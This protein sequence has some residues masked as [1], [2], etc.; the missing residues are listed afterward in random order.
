MWAFIVPRRSH[1]AKASNKVIKIETYFS[2]IPRIFLGQCTDVNAFS[3]FLIIIRVYVRQK[4]VN[5]NGL[6]LQMHKFLFHFAQNVAV[7]GY[8]IF[9]A[10]ASI[11]WHG[12]DANL[13]QKIRWKECQHMFMVSKPIRSVL[14]AFLSPVD[15][16]WYQHRVWQLNANAWNHVN[17][18]WTSLQDEIN[19]LLLKPNIS[20]QSSWHGQVPPIVRVKCLKGR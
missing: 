18:L 13:C 5:K 9:I 8:R 4:G 1:S 19:G 10:D 2:F 20:V 12:L 15:E 3:S 6:N 16:L 7:C 14:E 17:C 11:S